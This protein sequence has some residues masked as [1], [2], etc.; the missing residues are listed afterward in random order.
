M[1]LSFFEKEYCCY[2]A[3][4]IGYRL[5]WSAIQSSGGS[6]L[7]SH[8][9]YGRDRLEPDPSWQLTTPSHPSCGESFAVSGSRGL[10]TDF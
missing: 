4:I 9:F 10:I 6:S 1:S 7:P 2:G 3:V 5:V 8:G